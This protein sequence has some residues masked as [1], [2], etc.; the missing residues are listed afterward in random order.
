[1]SLY[2]Y[3]FG[4]AASGGETPSPEDDAGRGGTNALA[5][6]GGGDA[7]D[8]AEYYDGSPNRWSEGGGKERASVLTEDDEDDAFA[9]DDAGVCGDGRLRDALARAMDSDRGIDAGGGEGATAGPPPRKEEARR[10]R[11]PPGRGRRRPPA[12]EARQ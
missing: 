5:V 1:M 6:D 10:R 9:G 3:G 7:G 8:P 2:G 12:E 11:H 4:P